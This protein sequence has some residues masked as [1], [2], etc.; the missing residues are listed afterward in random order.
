MGL[1]TSRLD[2]VV[3]CDRKLDGAVDD[4]GQF[5]CQPALLAG[6]GLNRQDAEKE[7]YPK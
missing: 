5:G 3:N 1:N 4:G 6:M 7:D 2:F